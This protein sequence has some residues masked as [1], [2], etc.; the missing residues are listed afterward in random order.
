ML[1][2]SCFTFK[3]F[4]DLFDQLLAAEGGDSQLFCK[5]TQLAFLI[6]VNSSIVLLEPTSF[7]KK[8][9]LRP[10]FTITCWCGD[11]LRD[12]NWRRHR[13]LQL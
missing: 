11:R 3:L 6:L 4:L 8:E 12:R 9:R 1:D 7:P 2:L 10:T 5:L 13:G